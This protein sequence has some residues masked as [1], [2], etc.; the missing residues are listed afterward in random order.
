MERFTM[1]QMS[2]NCECI[3]KESL[4]GIKGIAPVYSTEYAACADIALP[5]ECTVKAGEVAKIDLLIAF[6]IPHNCKIVMYPRSSL[7]VKKGLIQPTSIID[8]DYS[9]QNVHAVLFN[10]GTEDV[11]LKAGERVAQITCEPV[12]DCYDWER[13][14]DK[15][16][17][18]FGSTGE[19]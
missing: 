11:T 3:I 10:P 9:G 12:Y 4:I 19:I 13:K 16:D 17:G 6:R 5:Y 7:L 8:A 15:R 2:T 1:Y 18:G 14:E